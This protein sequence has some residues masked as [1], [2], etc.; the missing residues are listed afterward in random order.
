MSS[1]YNQVKKIA[2]W[3]DNKMSKHIF[4]VETGSD[5]SD[6]DLKQIIENTCLSEGIDY[7]FYDTFK[8]DKD[9]M[10]D[11]SAM[12]KT[13]TILSEIAKKKNIF[14]GANIQLTDD[15]ALLKPLELTSNNIANSKQIK[16]VLDAL[17]L[18]REIPVSDYREYKYWKS[19]NDNPADVELLPLDNN[20][21][22]YVCKIDKNRAGSK[23]DLLF[24]LNLDTNIWTEEG[25]VAAVRNIKSISDRTVKHNNNGTTTETT[26]S[27]W[28]S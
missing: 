11:W 1:Q 21:R 14:I 23:P 24:S 27:K 10:G 25:R 7:V 26:I 9:A 13:A 3:I 6:S 15:A 20:K 16:H 5:Y 18:F 2:R 8:S 19:I 28:E 22:Y 17:C 12:K 4:I